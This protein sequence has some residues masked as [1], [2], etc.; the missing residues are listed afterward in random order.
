MLTPRKQAGLSEGDLI[1]YKGQIVRV[2]Y[3]GID[4]DQRPVFEVFMSDGGYRIYR[5]DPELSELSN[6]E[7]I[8]ERQKKLNEG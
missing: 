4:S 8:T 7:Q 1:K 3:A 2:D 6:D 5:D